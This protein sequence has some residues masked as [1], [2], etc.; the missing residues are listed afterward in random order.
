MDYALFRLT[1]EDRDVAVGARAVVC[2]FVIVLVADRPERFLLFVAHLTRDEVHSLAFV[3]GDDL[4]ILLEVDEAR[5]LVLWVHHLW[6]G[7]WVDVG[8]WVGGCRANTIN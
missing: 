5:A 3:L 7:E 2:E 4:R 1:V 6:V 8:G